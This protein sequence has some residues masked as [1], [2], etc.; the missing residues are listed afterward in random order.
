[1]ILLE[2]EKPRSSFEV[3]CA[4]H[5]CCATMPDFGGRSDKVMAIRRAIADGTYETPE[6][7]EIMLDRLIEDLLS[8][9]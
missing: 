9:R 5:C 3:G 4:G 1:M 2:T 8:N 6:K 7:L